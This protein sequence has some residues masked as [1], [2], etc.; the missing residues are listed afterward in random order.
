ML[1]TR[2]LA[3]QKKRPGGKKKDLYL[4]FSPEE[5]YLNQGGGGGGGGGGKGIAIIFLLGRA[6]NSSK[7]RGGVIKA[8]KTL[9]LSRNT[10]FRHYGYTSMYLSKIRVEQ[11]PRIKRS[12]KF[13]KRSYHKKKAPDWVVELNAKRTKREDTYEAVCTNSR[14]HETLKL[15]VRKRI[16]SRGESNQ[17]VICEICTSQNF[18]KF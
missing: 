11:T 6:R 8:K 18:Q 17:K 3:C 5:S 16:G 1:E 12:Q 10:A 9:V 13:E 14:S 2:R 4:T 7:K 15:Q